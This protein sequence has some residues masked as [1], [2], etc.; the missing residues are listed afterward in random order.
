MMIGWINY[1]VDSQHLKDETA[2]N[3][4]RSAKK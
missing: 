1:T 3:N 2:V 4:N